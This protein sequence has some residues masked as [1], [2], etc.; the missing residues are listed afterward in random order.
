[1]PSGLVMS[2]GNN[3]IHTMASTNMNA[4]LTQRKKFLCSTC[5]CGYDYQS[6]LDMHTPT[7][8]PNAKVYCETCGKGFATQHSMARY[9][10]VHL[11]LTFSCEQCPKQFN[12]KEKLSRHFPG[13]HGAGYWSLCGDFHFQW[14][15][16]RTCH[17]EK[18]DDCKEVKKQKLAHAF[19]EKECSV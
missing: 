17:Q 16:K 15:G 2:V 14:P 11:G 9:A 3:T 18:C 12:M 5:G 7:H 10:Q 1:M 19:P 13:S 6:Q 4:V 8:D